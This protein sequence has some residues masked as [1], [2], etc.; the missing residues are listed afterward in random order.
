MAGPADSEQRRRA[1]ISAG[2]TAAALLLVPFL[3]LLVLPGPPKIT[4]PQV[5][6]ATAEPDEL[7]PP[8]PTAKPASPASRPKPVA[9][10]EEATPVH[11]VVLAPDGAPMTRAWIGCSDRD[12]SAMTEKDGTFELPTEAIGCA[13]Y[14]RKAGFGA[15][16]KAKLQAGDA[17]QNTFQLRQGGKIEGVVVDEGGAPVTKFMLAVEKFIGAEG[18][19]DGSAGRA[20]TVEDEQGRF[21]ME[22][23]TPGKYVLSA[24]SDGRPPARSDSFDVEPG[25]S[26][27]GVRIVLA[28]GAVLRGIVTDAVTRKPVAGASVTLDSV[29]SS[30]ISSV[31]SVKTDESGAFVLEG[32]PPA[33]PF[34][35]RADR[36]GYR[37]RIVSGLTARGSGEVSTNIALSPREGDGGDMELGGIGAVLGPPPDSLGAM[38]LALTPDGPA[39]K[40]GL[41]KNDHIVRIDGEST[42]SMTL[43]DCI[44]R[45]RGEPGTR[46][47]VVVKRENKQMR[48]DLVRDTVVA[49]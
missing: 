48:Y 11:G 21:T 19:E 9:T 7:P 35:V 32:V 8:R 43:P 39:M 38:V 37:A 28:A 25:R 29:T 36:S 4:L 24:S 44:Q 16:D 46:V 40:A 45:L 22:G 3:M 12:Y 17:R 5:I 26:V 31:P 34:S 2:L 42:E 1:W 14:A 10:Q 30:G 49:R 47:S 13:A 23:V 15:S 18:E 27:T 41:Q 6:A 20:R 33:G